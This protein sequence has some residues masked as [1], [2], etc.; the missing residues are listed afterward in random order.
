M[1]VDCEGADFIAKRH[2]SAKCKLRA[3]EE[4]ILSI[5]S[6]CNSNSVLILMDHSG[7]L[8]IYIYIWILK[9]DSCVIK[10]NHDS[11]GH[12]LVLLKRGPL[13]YAIFNL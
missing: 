2:R 13:F 11:C 9:Y 8:Y 3:G 7:K 10:T 1:I 4:N 5:C 6:I 12:I